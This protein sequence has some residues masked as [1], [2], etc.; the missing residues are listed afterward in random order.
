MP[1][2]PGETSEMG[3]AG[4]AIESEDRLS[5]FSFLTSH[6]PFFSYNQS[7]RSST[8]V[9]A[10]QRRGKAENPGGTENRSRLPC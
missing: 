5:R 1:V 7:R 4:R 6:F 3:Y 10:G 8:F 2:M 9:R